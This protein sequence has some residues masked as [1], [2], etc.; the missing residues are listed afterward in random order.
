MNGTKLQGIITRQNLHLEKDLLI[1]LLTPQGFFSL[2]ARGALNSRRRF[3][4]GILEVGNFVEVLTE[5]PK[6]IEQ[7]EAIM[8]IKEAKLIK[9]FE[10]IRNSYSKVS[11][12]YKVM[13]FMNQWPKGRYEEWKIFSLLGVVLEC[14]AQTANDHLVLHST[15]LQFIVKSLYLE[16]LLRSDTTT[17][18]VLLKSP[19]GGLSGPVLKELPKYEIAVNQVLEQIGF[20]RLESKK[21]PAK[22]AVLR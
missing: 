15:Y 2:Y 21:Q 8:F 11:V 4:G 3:V 10:G 22:S 19:L 14:L 5:L 18:N 13:D 16:G 17:L 9:C 1:D 12:L 7:Q 6:A 20:F